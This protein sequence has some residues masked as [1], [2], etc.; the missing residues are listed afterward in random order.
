MAIGR[1]YANVENH[2]GRLEFDADGQRF[3]AIGRFAYLMARP[4]QQSREF[5][6]SVAIVIRNADLTIGSRWLL[7]RLDTEIRAGSGREIVNAQP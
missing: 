2:N 3:A 4:F 6:C 5:Q 1:R 7:Y